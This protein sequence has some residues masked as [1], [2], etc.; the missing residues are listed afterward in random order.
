MHTRSSETDDL[1]YGVQN[2]QPSTFTAA[3]DTHCSASKENKTACIL[4]WDRSLIQH[5]RAGIREDEYMGNARFE[6]S[7]SLLSG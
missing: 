1:R 6:P 4:A 3:L 7:N 2:V 5:C